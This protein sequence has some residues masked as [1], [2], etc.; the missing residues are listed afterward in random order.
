M[1]QPE[2]IPY[3]LVISFAVIILIFFVNRLTVEEPKE[4]L[5][6]TL[7]ITLIVIIILFTLSLIMILKDLP[8][9]SISGLS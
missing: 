4:S 5:R 6:E 9:Y 7:S 3:Q 2:F 8:P 1:S